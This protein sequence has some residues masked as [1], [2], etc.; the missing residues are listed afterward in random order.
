MS[1]FNFVRF[2]EILSYLFFEREL[3]VHLVLK[4]EKNKKMWAEKTPSDLM[5]ILPVP[6][7][8]GSH[9]D[10]LCKLAEF[11]E[12]LL[13]LWGY[14]FP[15]A[16]VTN[17]HKPGALGQQKCLSPQFWRLEVYIL[18]HWAEIPPEVLGESPF[19]VPV[20]VA[21]QHSFPGSWPRHSSF[22]DQHLQISLCC[23][24]T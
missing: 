9:R 8:G 16:T 22:W 10:Q 17:E 19:L 20:Y 21:C 4:S 18:Y 7:S 11:M 15:V 6:F 3:E 23:V 1:L 14:W 13:D 5:P 24:F 2:L 12:S